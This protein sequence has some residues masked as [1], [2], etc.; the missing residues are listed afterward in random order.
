MTVLESLPLNTLNHTQ[1]RGTEPLAS[2]LKI[3]IHSM[4]PSQLV[5][6]L[7]SSNLYTRPSQKSSTSRHTPSP[8]PFPNE[9]N[10][11]FIT[12]LPFTKLVHLNRSFCGPNH[13]P[14]QHHCPSLSPRL[15]STSTKKQPAPHGTHPQPPPH[16]ERHMIC[17]LADRHMQS[18]SSQSPL[19]KRHHWHCAPLPN[20]PAQTQPPPF[21]T[22]SSL[23]SQP[24][25][26]R[27]CVQSGSYCGRTPHCLSSAASAVL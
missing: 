3:Y 9:Y 18:W 27:V 12:S 10:R 2:I 24:P 4:H 14:D 8:Q 22:F 5:T 26:P 15:H 7:A 16:L 19:Q 6:C 1:G 25:P 23:P 20:I 21:H 13:H 11:S 17:G